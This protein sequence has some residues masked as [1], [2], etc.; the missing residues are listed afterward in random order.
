MR[1]KLFV[2]LVL[3]LFTTAL[4]SIKLNAEYNYS[5]W[6]EA[7]ESA[8]SMSITKIVDNVN[9]EDSSGNKPVVTLDGLYDS[10]VY[11]DLLYVSDSK[12]NK[13]YVFNS[14]LEYLES[15]PKE[16]DSAT[17]DGPLGVFVANNKLYVADSKNYRIAIFD[18][19]TKM[20]IQEIKDPADDIFLKIRFTPQRLVVDRSGRI[21]VVAQNVFEGIMEF[22]SSGNFTRFYGTNVIQMGVLEA[23][24]YRLSTKKQKEKMALKLQPSF[25][26]IDI[27]EFGYIYTVS[28][29]DS[30][31]PVKK[32]NFKGNDILIKNGYINVIGD[33]V[34]ARSDRYVA[35][36]PSTLSDI[37]VNNDNNRFSILDAK[38][39]RIF[40]YD[41]EG[42][43]LYIF[44]EKGSQNDKLQSPTS[45]TYFDEKVIVTDNTTKSIYVYE[46]T[47]FGLLINQ[48]TQAY[49][50]MDYDASKTY[51]NE[52][53]SE[54]SNYFLAYAGIGKTNLR[55]HEYQ[56]AIENLK[57]GHDYFNYSKAYKEYRTQQMKKVLPYLIVGALGLLTFIVYKS[58]RQAVKRD[59]DE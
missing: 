52:V 22:D 50:Q 18:L 32:L 27:D 43:L 45:I 15:Y 1:K 6:I 14:D 41:I 4:F 28:R 30:N 25:T 29:A 19:T 39:A 26:S 24:I 54:N 31:N 35:P 21:L 2:S 44:G 3:L 40:T 36:G 20:L 11:E 57:L 23:L 38:R 46:P 59:E 5:P 12:Q 13:V 9:I 17:L 16:T 55:N 53:V 37:T 58:I 8:H 42:H 33:A 56:E 7:I 48:A 10:H 34:Y 49:Y 51:W 47:K